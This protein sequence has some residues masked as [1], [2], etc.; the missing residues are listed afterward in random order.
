MTSDEYLLTASKT[1]D[2]FAV[3]FIHKQNFM[4]KVGLTASSTLDNVL[5]KWWERLTH[6]PRFSMSRHLN[7][8]K[9]LLSKWTAVSPQ[10]KEKLFKTYAVIAY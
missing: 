8:K 2:I 7:P 3:R 9:L 10:H 1:A 4:Q 5:L 6:K